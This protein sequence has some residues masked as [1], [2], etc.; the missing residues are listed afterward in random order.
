MAGVAGFA[1]EFDGAQRACMTGVV[2]AILARENDDLHVRRMRQ[3]F[4]DQREALVRAVRLRRQAEVDQCHLRR[5]A[6][7]VEQGQTCLLYTSRCV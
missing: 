3:Q 5:L 2:L 4:A 7:L 6:Q 1:D